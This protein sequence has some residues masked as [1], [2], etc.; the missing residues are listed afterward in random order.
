MHLLYS[1]LHQRRFLDVASYGTIV[2]Q[3]FITHENGMILTASFYL[4][5]SSDH[6]LCC[7][8]YS[9]LC[10]LHHRLASDQAYCSEEDCGGLRKSTCISFLSEPP[11]LS[12]HS[13]RGLFLAAVPNCPDTGTRIVV[14]GALFLCSAVL[15][16][17]IVSSSSSPLAIGDV[18][19]S[20]RVDSFS[21]TPKIDKLALLNRRSMNRYGG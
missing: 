5:D 20:L 19:F 14:A 6:R 18:V 8:T 9:R 4:H 3:S 15:E 10:Q 11:L 13:F 21:E 1:R 7:P 12:S 2:F 16:G 17:M